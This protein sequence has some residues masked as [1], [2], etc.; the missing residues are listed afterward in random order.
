MKMCRGLAHAG[1]SRTLQALA[2]KQGQVYQQFVSRS[3]YFKVPE[4]YI[5]TERIQRLIDYIAT[6]VCLQLN[7]IVVQRHQGEPAHQHAGCGIELRVVHHH[8][9]CNY[10]ICAFTAHSRFIQ[11]YS[12]CLM[13]A[14]TTSRN[15]STFS[16]SN[17]R[18]FVQYISPSLDLIRRAAMSYAVSQSHTLSSKLCSVMQSCASPENAAAFCPQCLGR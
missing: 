10:A 8:K 11:V 2:H 13:M 1:N 7:S 18:S 16:R 9:C 5:C 15:V 12:C 4:K 3:F 14:T 17:M 6:I